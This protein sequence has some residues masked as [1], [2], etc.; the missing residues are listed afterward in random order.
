MYLLYHGLKLVLGRFLKEKRVE[1]QGKLNKSFIENR[2]LR[3][4]S[5]HV[6]AA[7][8]VVY[9]L[10]YST[11]FAKYVAWFK[12]QTSKFIIIFI[13]NFLVFVKNNF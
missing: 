4:G 6:N 8:L 13:T 7:K 10:C 12:V 3:D 11:S 5:L 2:R 9:A 1:V